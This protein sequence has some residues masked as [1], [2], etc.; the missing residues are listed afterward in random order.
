MKFSKNS[1]AIIAIL[2]SSFAH[3]G[4]QVLGF[5]IE[6]STLEQVNTSLSKQTKV[7]DN[8][9]NK[10]SA[11]TMLR[12]N[13]SSYE[14]EGLN[15]VLYIFDDQ[16]K[17]AGVIMNMNKNRFDTVYQAVSK[18]YKVAS[19]NRPFVGNQF[20]RFKTPDS[21]IEIDA[22]H[23]SFEMEVRYIRKDFLQKFNSQSTAEAESK[24]KR[25][26]SNF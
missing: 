3:A 24:K 12:T 13:G 7:I 2:A 10:F 22:P 25:E 1:L 14:I 6:A 21:T 9:I 17:L 19:Q 20:A 18:K 5:E 4:T 26:A 15:D 8:G 16:Q 23:L 11:G